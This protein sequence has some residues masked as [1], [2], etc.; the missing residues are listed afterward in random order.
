VPGSSA[1]YKVALLQAG[2]L[3]TTANVTVETLQQ[4]VK[5]VDVYH[6]DT[7]IYTVA[8]KFAPVAHQIEVEVR[9]RACEY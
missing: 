6:A 1:S 8:P 5:L 9:N 7:D 2:L 4:R 3:C